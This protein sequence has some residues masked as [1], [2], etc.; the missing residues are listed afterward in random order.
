MICHTLM[1]LDIES[2][3]E[4]IKIKLTYWSLTVKTPSLGKSVTN[5]FFMSFFHD[6]YKTF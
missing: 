1:T 4:K 3:A 2:K 5:T 6:K